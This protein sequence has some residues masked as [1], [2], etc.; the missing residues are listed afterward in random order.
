MMK[1]SEEEASCFF[2]SIDPGFL[3]GMPTLG[4]GDE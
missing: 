1:L 2:Q 3:D 4:V